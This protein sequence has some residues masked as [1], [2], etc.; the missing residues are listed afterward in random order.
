MQRGESLPNHTVCKL[1]KSLYGLKQA[2]RQWFAKFSSTLLRLGFVQT[3]ADS[4]LF[5]RNH[6][7]VFLALIV[8]VDIVIATNNEK[9]A[10]DFKTLLNSNFCLK[11]LRD[12]RYFL[13][14]EVARS[15]RCISICQRH[16]ALQFVNEAG[17]LGCKTRTT[18]MDV[19]LKL[20]HE[21]G[22][23]LP[24]ASFYRD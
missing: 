22:E 4:S 19:N 6:G 12:L 18:P 16:Y 5:V 7:D 23:L 2:S 14:I 11:V 24:D 3:H 10:T 21:D 17:L 20:N 15:K 13:G 1:H 8:Y 9:E